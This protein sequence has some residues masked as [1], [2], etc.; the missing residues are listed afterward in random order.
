MTFN[1]KLSQDIY[2]HLYINLGNKKPRHPAGV[3]CIGSFG[4]TPVVPYFP[5]A[6]LLLFF[7]GTSCSPCIHHRK[8]QPGRIGAKG[9]N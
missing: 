6:Y 3:F 7:S 1:F 4:I 2:F 9:G 8:S 5:C